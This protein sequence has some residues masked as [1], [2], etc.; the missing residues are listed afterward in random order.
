MIIPRYSNPHFLPDAT[1]R[2]SRKDLYAEDGDDRDGES[3]ETVEAIERLNEVIRQSLDAPDVLEEDTRKRKRRKIDQQS[4]VSIDTQEPIRKWWAPSALPILILGAVF[5]LV[6]SSSPI[7]LLI[8]PKPP[9][10]SRQGQF[11]RFAILTQ[12]FKRLENAS[13]NA[14]IMTCRLHL[15][16]NRHTK[17]QS[18]HIG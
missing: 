15:G 13:S 9:P 6:S 4:H 2:V 10:P 3:Q 14:K 1:Q 8:Q 11:L 12:Y 5:R 17:S 18:M 16:R 7:P